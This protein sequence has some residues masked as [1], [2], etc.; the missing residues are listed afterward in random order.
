MVAEAKTP[1]WQLAEY[2][3]EVW[4][5][6]LKDWNDIEKDTGGEFYQ[7]FTDIM[8][9]RLPS[10]PDPEVLRGSFNQLNV[11][12]AAFHDALYRGVNEPDD[13]QVMWLAFDEA[14][15][16]LGKRLNVELPDLRPRA[17]G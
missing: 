4:I 17:N 8:D 16:V 11:L 1:D 7:D 3:V 12:N 5:A 13:L 14:I 15:R 6:L 2:L 10:N 9:A